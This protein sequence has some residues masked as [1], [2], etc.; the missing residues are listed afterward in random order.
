MLFIESFMQWQRKLAGSAHVQKSGNISDRW[1]L[2][3]SLFT[4]F[5]GEGRP[6]S[7]TTFI[8]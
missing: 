5:D 1:K 6:S 8:S 2:Q 4:V 7:A 3:A